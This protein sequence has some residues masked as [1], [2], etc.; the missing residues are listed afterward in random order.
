MILDVDY[1]AEYPV[2]CSKDYI[3]NI[4]EASL[5]HASKGLHM[6]MMARLNKEFCSTNLEFGI[7]LRSRMRPQAL[8][9]ILKGLAPNSSAIQLLLRS[10]SI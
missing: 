7:R 2:L 6:L 1:P 8:Q 5:K 4:L 3:I 9:K 10:C